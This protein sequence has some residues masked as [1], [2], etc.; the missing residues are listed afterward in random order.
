MQ[1]I[2]LE[3]CWQSALSR[4]SSQRGAASTQLRGALGPNPLNLI[5]EIKDFR[6]EDAKDKANTMRSYW[7]PGVNNL[8]KFGRWG[9]AEFTAVYEME[10]EFAKL[11]GNFGC[12]GI[13]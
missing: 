9:F 11:I 6:G 5:V 10:A 12:V 13:V 3:P 1:K 2:T 4:A 7:V 8:G